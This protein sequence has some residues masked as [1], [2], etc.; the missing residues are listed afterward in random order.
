MVSKD[1]VGAPFVRAT[2]KLN[3]ELAG[4]NT[5][6]CAIRILLNAENPFAKGYRF[7]ENVRATLLQTIFKRARTE[8]INQRGNLL[9]KSA[10]LP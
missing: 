4:S 6:L 8:R 2:L 7:I 9:L 10:D 1:H 3:I 5:G